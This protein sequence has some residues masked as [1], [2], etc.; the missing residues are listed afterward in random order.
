MLP[1]EL[2]D[3]LLVEEAQLEAD[4]EAVEDGVDQEDML[5]ELL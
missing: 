1:V 2:G 4:A 3:E 5:S